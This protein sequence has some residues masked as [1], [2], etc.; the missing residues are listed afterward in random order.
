MSFVVGVDVGSRS[1][2]VLAVSDASG[3]ILATATFPIAVYKSN[4]SLLS[5]FCFKFISLRTV[6]N[7]S[8]SNKAQQ[9]FGMLSSHALGLWRNLLCL[10]FLWKDGGTV[11]EGNWAPS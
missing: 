3:T 6:H 9:T 2:R 4:R 5:S 10:W 8:S 11:F 1:V 7:R